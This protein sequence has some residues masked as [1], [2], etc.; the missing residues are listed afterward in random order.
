M[1][2]QAPSARLTSVRQLALAVR[3][4]AGKFSVTA[5]SGC[6]KHPDWPWPRTGPWHT[7]DIE[8]MI[9]WRQEDLKADPTDPC[10]TAGMDHSAAHPFWQRH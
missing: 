7:Y 10:D 8:E 6:T 5:V 4:V 9:R 2:R 3:K 1:G